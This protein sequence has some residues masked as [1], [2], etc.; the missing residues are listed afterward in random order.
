MCTC[1]VTSGHLP[2]RLLCPWDSLGKNT[3]VSCH[4][5]LQGII[6]T[7]GSNPGLMSPALASGFLPLV[8]SWEA[9]NGSYQYPFWIGF[10]LLLW[11]QSRFGYK[12]L[13]NSSADLSFLFHNF[14]QTRLPSPKAQEMEPI[15]PYWISILYISWWNHCLV[16]AWHWDQ[17]LVFQAEKWSKDTNFP[18]SL[19]TRALL[20]GQLWAPWIYYSIY[21]PQLSF[22]ENGRDDW[23]E[24]GFLAE[25]EKHHCDIRRNFRVAADTTLN[26]TEWLRKKCSPS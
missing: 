5:L 12:S 10:C 13:Y 24:Q 6:P 19:K 25:G 18:K 1:S 2:A 16:N 20:S 17:M 14:V 22:L 7:Q 3:R 8:P 26:H 21:E 9:P 15:S 11:H 23:K 4:A